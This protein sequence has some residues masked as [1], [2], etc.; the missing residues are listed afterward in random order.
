VS[1]RH[2]NRRCSVTQADLDRLHALVKNRDAPQNHVW[3]AHIVF[4]NAEGVGTNVITRETGKAKTCVWR[5]RER[6]AEG[7]EPPLREK[8]R[9]SCIPKLA[10][11]VAERV[12]ELTMEPPPGETTHWTSAA[13]AKSVGVSVSSIQLIWRFHGFQPH[14][15]RQ[16]KLSKDPEFVSKLRDIVGLCV[17]PPAH[18]VVLSLDGKYRIKELDQTQPALPIKKGR[19][20]TRTCAPSPTRDPGDGIRRAQPGV[21]L[22]S[23]APA[24]AESTTMR[25]ECE[26]IC[27]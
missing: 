17:N 26:S 15:V 24:S 11:S 4:L 14:C 6:F 7:G 19:A 3:L 8:T 22:S 9:P 13:M 20:G 12:V 25:D 18:A 23:K 27:R 16:F 5:W 21:R 2:A 10:P 1:L